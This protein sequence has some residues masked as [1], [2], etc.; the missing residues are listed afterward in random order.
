MS[1]S[2]P[3]SPTAR[4]PTLVP[5]V[6]TAPWTARCPR[7]GGGSGR[8][9]E[10]GRGGGCG[11][12]GGFDVRPRPVRSRLYQSTRPSIP[13]ATVSASPVTCRAIAGEAKNST[14]AAT[15]AVF[16]TRRSGMVR[17]T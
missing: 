9:G 11:T 3:A 7:L 6:Q 14:A 15:S 10:A 12:L 2:V 1:S 4:A 5:T 13:P 17:V 16:A 8:P